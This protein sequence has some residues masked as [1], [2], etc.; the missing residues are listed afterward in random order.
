MERSREP[1]SVCR[2]HFQDRL[3]AGPFSYGNEKRSICGKRAECDLSSDGSWRDR[4]QTDRRDDCPA[5]GTLEEEWGRSRARRTNRDCALW[6]TH[7]YL[8]SPGCANY[9]ETGR[10]CCRRFKCFGPVAL[11]WLSWK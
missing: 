9:C 6:L 7:G 1:L 4:L 2:A 10:F 5:R 8:A 11:R 3:P